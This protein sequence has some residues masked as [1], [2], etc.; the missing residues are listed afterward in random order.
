MSLGEYH[1]ISQHRVNEHVLSQQKPGWS[2]LARNASCQAVQDTLYTVHAT[3]FNE[4]LNP[5]AI[6]Y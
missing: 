1:T 3:S 4:S 6:A 2:L 5:N